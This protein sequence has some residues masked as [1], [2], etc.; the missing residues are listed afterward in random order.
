MANVHNRYQRETISTL[1][2]VRAR[3]DVVLSELTTDG[4]SLRTLNKIQVL[5]SYI[6]DVE[7]SAAVWLIISEEK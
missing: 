4:I 6:G 3:I 5:N 1:K 7:K 2:D